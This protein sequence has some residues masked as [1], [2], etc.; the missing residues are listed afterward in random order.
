MQPNMDSEAEFIF[1]KW[2][3]QPHPSHLLSYDRGKQ[4]KLGHSPWWTGSLI[5][6]PWNPVHVWL[7]NNQVQ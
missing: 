7:W 2:P 4:G 6:L 3:Q 1:Q 5:P